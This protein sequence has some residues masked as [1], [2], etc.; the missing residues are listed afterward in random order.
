MLM[1]CLNRYN[2]LIASPSPAP[3]KWAVSHTHQECT[4]HQLSPYIGKLR[5]GNPTRLFWHG[6]SQAVRIPDAYRFNGVTEV[7]IRKVGDALVL[8]PVRKTWES[9]AEEA[10]AVGEDFYPNGPSWQKSAESCL[11]A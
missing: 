5:Y 9:Y 4:L 11:G 2:E 6:R 10:P 3:T 8:A 7:I 1:N